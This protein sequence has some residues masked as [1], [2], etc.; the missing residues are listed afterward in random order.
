[1]VLSA[2]ASLSFADSAAAYGDVNED[3][4]VNITDVVLV[5]GNIVGNIAFTDKQAQ[6]ADINHDGNIDVA[7]VV[8]LRNSIV[9]NVNQNPSDTPTDT[10][11]ETDTSTDTAIDLPTVEDEPLIIEFEQGTYRGELNTDYGHGGQSIEFTA[12][13]HRASVDFTVAE[14]GKYVIKAYLI[15]PFGDKVGNVYFAAAGN[16][17]CAINKSNNPQEFAI[18][19]GTLNAGEKYT[20]RASA[21]WTYIFADY[22]LVEKASDTEPDA[23]SEIS[24][25]TNANAT[26]ETKA[27]YDYI[28][29]LYGKGIL[30]GQQESTWMDGGNTEYEMEYIYNRTGK[31]PAIR[32][33]DFMDD[34]FDGCVKRA[35]DWHQRG[36]IVTICWHC[37]PN[38]LDGYKECMGKTISDWNKALTPGTTEYDALIA[39]MDKGAKALLKL[40]EA[41]VPVLWRPFHEFD[42]KWFWWGKGGEQNFIKLWQLMYDRY[43]NHWGLNN[44]IWVLGYSGNGINYGNWYPGDEYVD[45]AGADSYNGGVQAGLFNS[46]KS[47]VNSKKALCFHECGDN[48]T[49]QSLIDQNVDWVWFMT[50]HSS[51]LTD[52]NTASELNELYNSDYAITLDELPD[53]GTEE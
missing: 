40:Q 13:S 10:D 37:G 29:Q 36:G 8:L 27:L 6:S 50:W 47:V 34:D 35:I 9:N 52:N 11:T 23:P 30:T 22:V 24:P 2:S 25:I 1:M 32:G 20:V 46:V 7:D 31:L 41:G 43:T 5:R 28:A 4:T 18:Y 49:V 14:T 44:L 16:V 39:G 38:F 19:T 21:N 17:T 33:L 45:I 15:S 51:Q 53:F 12:E 48:P 3:S 26:N 42:G